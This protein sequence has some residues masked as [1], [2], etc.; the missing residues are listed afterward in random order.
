M[1]RDPRYYKRVFLNSP[2]DAEH[3]EVLR[4]ITV[5]LLDCG[6]LPACALQFGGKSRMSRIIGL[7]GNS[8]Y[9][10]HNFGF[11]LNGKMKRPRLNM[12]LEVGVWYG[13]KAFQAD[14]LGEDGKALARNDLL[15]IANFHKA[16]RTRISDLDAFDPHDYQGKVKRAIRI[17]L[18]WIIDDKEGVG[19]D[20]GKLPSPKDLVVR[21]S[22]FDAN[23]TDWANRRGLV[24]A[25]QIKDVDRWP[26]YV[27]AALHY[28][29]AHPLPKR[30]VV[31][32]TGM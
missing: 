7:I 29:E 26:D 21:F 32:P 24:D 31:P 2:F 6:L 14:E 9:A 10:I 17:A 30:E 15:L 13:A 8:R 20:P 18:D 27:K 25:A 3:Y 19:L 4:A 11:T 28:L 1:D 5:V 22:D 16:D 23:A 12:P